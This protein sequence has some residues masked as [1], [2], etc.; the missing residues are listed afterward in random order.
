MSPG[1]ALERKL[2]N[3]ACHQLTPMVG[4]LEGNLTLI[5]EAVAEACSDGTDVL[6]LPEL[7]TSGY[8]FRSRAEARSVAMTT[9]HPFFAET[10]AALGGT[11]LVVVVGFCE[12]GGEVLYNSAA[13]IDADGVSAVYRKTHLWDRETQVFEPGNDLPPVVDT[14]HGRIG[15]LICYDMEFPEMPRLLA[16]AGADLIAVPTN[17]PSGEHPVAERAAEVIAAQA[18]AR[19]NGVFIA[20][21][22]RAGIERGQSWNEATVIVSQYGWVVADVPDASGARPV[23]RASLSLHLA[24]DKSISPHNGLLAD[25][26]PDL[27]RKGTLTA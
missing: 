5:G 16:L 7:S 13:L 14:V 21:C 4:D 3:V 25:R 1:A 15:L 23:A 8:V 26:R 6:V 18:A 10:S 20:C 19:T 9:D 27:Y 12:D 11:S 2:T 17:W 24:E 22:D